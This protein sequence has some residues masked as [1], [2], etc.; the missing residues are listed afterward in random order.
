MGTGTIDA[1]KLMMNIE[2]TPILSVK[3][4]SERGYSLDRYFGDASEYMTFDSVE[5]D[6]ETMQALGIKRK[7]K[8]ENGMLII[9]PGKSG[10]G[11]LTIKAIAGGNTV[12]GSMQGDFSGNG[13]I[14]TVPGYEGMG[15]MYITREISIISRGV[16]SN[17]GGWL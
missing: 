11:K 13:D 6:R 12:A 2:G 17:N 5:M 15:G 9:N 3:V 8:V 10:S 4:G 16:A 14:V 7:P 1:W